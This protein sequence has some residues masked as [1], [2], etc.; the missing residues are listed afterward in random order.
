MIKSAGVLDVKP[1]PPL[2]EGAMN[3]LKIL[4]DRYIQEGME[5]VSKLMKMLIDLVDIFLRCV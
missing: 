1:S 2:D 5:K 3:I 4:Y